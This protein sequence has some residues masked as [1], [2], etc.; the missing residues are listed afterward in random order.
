MTGHA[1]NLQ[2]QTRGEG[3]GIVLLSDWCLVESGSIF[4]W[5]HVKAALFIFF[6]FPVQ[7]CTAS[8]ALTY[9]Q[10]CCSYLNLFMNYSKCFKFKLFQK[11]KRNYQLIHGENGDSLVQVESVQVF[12]TSASRMQSRK[13]IT[14]NTSEMAHRLLQKS[15]SCSES[16]KDPEKYSLIYINLFQTNIVAASE[17]P[18]VDI[19]VKNNNNNKN[20]NL[21]L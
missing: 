8:L 4:F 18:A 2:E 12:I 17:L 11:E 13:C 5:Q 7:M 6:P 3:E 10:G 19:N 15:W 21:F 14:S 16:E 9:F 1:R 20:L